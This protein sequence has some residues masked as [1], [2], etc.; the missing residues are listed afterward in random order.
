MYIHAATTREKNDE[1]RHNETKVR[2]K[3]VVVTERQ[4]DRKHV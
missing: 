3:C 1:R 2:D 4:R